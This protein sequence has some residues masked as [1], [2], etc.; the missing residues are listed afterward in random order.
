VLLLLGH[1]ALANLAPILTLALF[2]AIV[3]TLGR[4]YR[5]SEMVVWF[6][7]GA[8]LARFIAPVLAMSMPI[9]VLVAL[10]M[11]VGWPW[12]NREGIELRERFAAR[13]D[14]ARVAPGLFQSSADGRRVFF[15][16][17]DGAG[18]DRARNVFIL[19]LAERGE[20][21]T[22][23]SSG[24]LE[25]RGAESFITLRDGQ[26]NETDDR[27]GERSVA[28]FDSYSVL[29]KTTDAPSSFDLPPR[30]VTTLSLLG[31][32]SPAHDGEL[33]WR[34]GM[35]FAAVNLSLLGIGLANVNPRR[36]S[37]WNLLFALL[38][39]I[40]YFNLLNVA[41]SWVAGGRMG[42]GAALLLLHGSA[43][44]I[45]CLTIVWRDQGMRRLSLPVWRMP[46]ATGP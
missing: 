34:L 36:M 6:C 43:F 29:V 33:A 4:M 32:R 27:S 5:Q 9:V 26:R 19:S 17:H 16:D 11:L 35:I 25:Q 12:V 20:S 10:L 42:L 23:A 2:V 41:K 24:R 13:A 22:T 1:A 14:V 44:A 28:R 7:S 15:I 3:L 18:P 37:N 46:R 21:M 30:A 31:A 8:P 39:F 38:A 40:V 45:A